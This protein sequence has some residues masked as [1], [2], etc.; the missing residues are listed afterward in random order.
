MSLIRNP[1]AW[2]LGLGNFHTIY[3]TSLVH[4]NSKRGRVDDKGNKKQTV[5]SPT[6]VG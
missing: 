1:W 6:V 3:L 4:M 5:Q 2:S